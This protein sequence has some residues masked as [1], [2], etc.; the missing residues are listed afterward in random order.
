MIMKK[1]ILLSIIL[2]TT[3]NVFCEESM[4]SITVNFQNTPNKKRF[5]RHFIAKALKAHKIY[6]I[7][8]DLG[9]AAAINSLI[10]ANER[11]ADI[12]ILLGTSD[13]IATNNHPY[14][15]YVQSFGIPLQIFLKAHPEDQGIQC[16]FENHVGEIMLISPL[17]ISTYTNTTPI[18]YYL[19][20][21]NYLITPFL[22]QLNDLWHS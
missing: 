6:I 2:S 19:S 18:E 13:V 8:Y 17:N 21:D 22:E 7:T 15:L 10:A 11:R 16:Y 1:I 9:V 4:Q 20:S 5:L 12:K 3:N 14:V